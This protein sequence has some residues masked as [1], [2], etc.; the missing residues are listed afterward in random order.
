MPTQQASKW[1]TAEKT[2]TQPSFAVSIR[3]PSVADHAT[4]KVCISARIPRGIC[5]PRTHYA[6]IATRLLSSD[7]PTSALLRSPRR[8]RRR[9]PVGRRE[10]NPAQPLP[11]PIVSAFTDSFFRHDLTPNS[12]PE[13]SE[14]A[15]LAFAYTFRYGIPYLPLRGSFPAPSTGSRFITLPAWRCIRISQHCGC[16]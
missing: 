15:R 6:A 11:L 1:S 8:V 16:F 3:M 13:K 9:E 4:A 12:C 7:P 10:A 2:H 14:A 5:H